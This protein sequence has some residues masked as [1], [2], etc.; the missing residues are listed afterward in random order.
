MPSGSRGVTGLSIAPSLPAYRH[1]IA[2]LAVALALS[3]SHGA[4]G[5][6][7][8]GQAGSG[9]AGS[10]Q[11]NPDP[12]ALRAAA[13]GGSPAAQY[14]YAHYLDGLPG[15]RSGAAEWYRR[16]AEQGHRDAQLR[17]A[18][19][20]ERGEG[21][22]AD[23]ADARRYYRQAVDAGAG[24]TAE[25]NLALMLEEGRGGDRD[26]AEAARL[27]RGAA[28]TGH[29]RA[30]NNLGT[31]LAKGDGIPSDRETAESWY[32]AAARAGLAD[33]FYNLG[34]LRMAD[35]TPDVASAHAWFE[36][37]L[38][39]NDA[40]VAPLARNALKV[41]EAGMTPEVMQ[42]AKELEEEFRRSL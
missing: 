21:V 41:I 37:A 17:L 31:L 27:Y 28:L 10:G 20:L 14:W 15:E 16:A 26:A 7:A 38:E 6:T 42:R 39:R 12:A 3:F 9:Q 22:T 33:A 8:A 5:Q 19:M 34:V 18:Q 32:R 1:G 25:F 35:P 24:A 40:H 11:A 29:A 13:E 36:L 30:A 4:A 23:H 2:V